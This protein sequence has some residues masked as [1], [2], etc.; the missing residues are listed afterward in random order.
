MM[1]LP[2]G[3]TYSMQYLTLI[4]KRPDGLETRHLSGVR[5]VPMTGKIRE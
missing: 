2:M 1:V 5:F 3:P 4:I